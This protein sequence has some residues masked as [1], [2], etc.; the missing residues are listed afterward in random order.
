MDNPQRKRLQTAMRTP[1]IPPW[2]VHRPKALGGAWGGIGAVVAVICAMLVAV[3]VAMACTNP[4]TVTVTASMKAFS[5]NP[6]CVSSPATASLPAGYTPPPGVSEGDLSAEYT[7]SVT[8]VQYKGTWLNFEGKVAPYGTATSGSYITPIPI[9]PKQ[10]SPSPTATLTF[11]PLIAGHWRKFTS[12]SVSVRD[13]KTNQCWNGTANAAP[14]TLTS[15]TVSFSPNP[16]YTGADNSNPGAIFVSVTATV[17]PKDL[18]NNVNVANFATLPGSTGAAAVENYHSNSTTGQITLDL[19]GTAGTAPSMPKGDVEIE[20]KDGNAVLGT[21]IVTIEIPKAISPPLPTFNHAVASENR[22]LSGS[23]IPAVWGLQPGQVEL[24]TMAGT[25]QTLTVDD[26]FGKVLSGL[27]NGQKVRENGSGLFAA[28]NVKIKNGQYSDWVGV[29]VDAP[30]PNPLPAGSQ[31]AQNW[32]NATPSTIP[33]SG[34]RSVDWQ[35]QVAG[36]TLNPG[37]AS[38]SITYSNGTLIIT[39]P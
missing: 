28:I 8:S 2:K 27:Y 11:T 3:K 20:G 16:L 25:A 35:V 37:I 31:K 5:P 30:A 10:P 22:A 4:G 32:A 39:W 38:R 24:A 6:V 7:W 13:A 18:I 1:I 9:I 14:Q 17:A 29:G 36:F 23:S 21:A 34:P 26:Q 12:C 33:N 15:A 19:Y